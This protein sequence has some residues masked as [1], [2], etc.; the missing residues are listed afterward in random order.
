MYETV[1]S[2]SK[3]LDVKR[4]G[5][6]CAGEESRG[7]NGQEACQD[8]MNDKRAPTNLPYKKRQF[9]GFYYSSSIAGHTH[10]FPVQVKIASIPH[11]ARAVIGFFTSEA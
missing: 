8:V 6:A 11:K 5:V 10:G 1:R 4:M 2:Q 7:G 3:S 9:P